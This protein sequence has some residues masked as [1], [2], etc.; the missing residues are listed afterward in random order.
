[1]PSTS[2]CIVM[3]RLP[4]FINSA[5]SNKQDSLLSGWGWSWAVLVAVGDYI[6]ATE[7]LAAHQ[8][9]PAISSINRIL[10]IINAIAETTTHVMI[11]PRSLYLL[12]CNDPLTNLTGLLILCVVLGDPFVLSIIG[13]IIN[14]EK[15]NVRGSQI[16]ISPHARHG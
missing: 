11:S 13:T 9:L 1:M 16:K 3:P 10:N 6:D 14:S 2:W 12:L 8:L 4:S 15:R 7:E 5:I